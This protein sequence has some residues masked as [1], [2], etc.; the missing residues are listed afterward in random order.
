[1]GWSFHRSLNFGGLRLNLSRSGI[2]ASVGVKGFRYGISPSGRRYVRCGMD[3]IYYQQTVGGGHRLQS[4]QN[5]RSPSR[6]PNYNAARNATGPMESIQSAEASTIVDSTSAGLIKEIQH[7]LNTPRW[8]IW[9]LAIGLAIVILCAAQQITFLVILGIALTLAGFLVGYII[10]RSRST[11]EIYYNLDSHYG[12]T[13]AQLLSGFEQLIKS[14]RLWQVETTAAVQNSKYHGGAT[15]VQGR[16]LLVALLGLPPFLNVNLK[17]P[18]LVGSKQSLYFLPDV[19]LVVQG[20]RVGAVSYYHLGFASRVTPFIEDGVPASDSQQVGTT[21]R[22]VNKSGGPDR[23]FANNRQLPILQYAELRFQSA[24]GL[25][26]Q[27]QASNVQ[28]AQAF[29]QG[30]T[31]MM[32]AARGGFAIKPQRQTPPLDQSHPWRQML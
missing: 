23:R 7:R 4:L 20:R 8:H 19:V 13:Y 18:M 21:W 9:S 16:K 15:S 6:I 12:K 27:I 28:C 1:M 10:Y 5:G 3:G 11:T 17:M 24:S 2:G 29:V 32:Q 26:E 30:L 14:Q 31:I 25:N 22:F